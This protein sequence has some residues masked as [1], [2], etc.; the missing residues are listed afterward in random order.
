MARKR[1]K[2][3]AYRFLVRKPNGKRHH[4]EDLSFAGVL[5]IIKKYGKSRNPFIWLRTGANAGFL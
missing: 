1:E 5:I 4:L 3:N 2:R